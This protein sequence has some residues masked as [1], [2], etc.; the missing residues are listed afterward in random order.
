MEKL[1]VSQL[2]DILSLKRGAFFAS[3]VTTTEP[4]MRKTG[5]PYHGG[6]KKVSRSHV[7]LNSLYENAVN[8]QRKREGVEEAFEAEPRKWGER[9]YRE[10]GTVTTFV[11]HNGKLYIEARVLKS[12]E[13]DYLFEGVSIP[14][15]L[16]KPYLYSGGESSRQGVEKQVILRDYSVENIKQITFDGKTYGIE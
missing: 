14:S 2:L 16:V 12:L 8:N 10:D 6:I 9:I 1:T 15:E 7:Q 13:T 4:K 11:K 5:N 3:I